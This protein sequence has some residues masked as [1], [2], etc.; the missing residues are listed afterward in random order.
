MTTE[1]DEKAKASKEVVQAI[2]KYCVPSTF[3]YPLVIKGGDGCHIEGLDGETY[4]DLN[5]N[6]CSSPLGYNH[7]RINEAIEEVAATG[8]HKVAGQDFYTEQH[9]DLAEKLLSISPHE[10]SKTFFTNTGTEAVENCLKL[11]YRKRGALP[12]V[13][14]YGAFH[15]RTLGAL[16][17]TYSKPVQKYN[18]PQ[19]PY[20]RIPFVTED[21][22]PD[23]DAIYDI[24]ENEEVA[25]IILEC[26]Q[27]EGGYNKAAEDFV[28]NLAKASRNHDVPL[29]VD[30]VQ[31]G[32]G[33]TGEWWA[34]QNYGIEPH[35]FAV[36]KALQ[37]GAT[38]LRDEFAPEEGGVVSSTWGGG[39]RIDLN[40]GLA[41]I[42]TIEEENLLDNAKTIG[43]FLLRGIEDIQE[44][45]S[46]RIDETGGLGLM[47][48]LRFKERE[49]RDRVVQEAF[50]QGLLLLP[51]GDRNIRLA[52]P[53]IIDED[54]AQ[55]GL[56]LLEES[57]SSTA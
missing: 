5:S 13:S 18:F 11:A 55:R 41:I 34:F 7:P 20:R 38:V 2:K 25:F 26:V 30:E 54:T 53:L 12:G 31:T 47:L 57:I 42:E 45:H 44:A 10:F 19:V 24:V 4:L 46:S 37:V 27:G 49:D 9:G 56:E 29:V 6:V 14:C 48:K 50:R 51:A 28:R 52:P 16:T 23:A 40:V 1:V 32:L 22:D 8:A 39:H 17:F 35:L 15:G 3:A 21:D 36:G 33:R 43:R